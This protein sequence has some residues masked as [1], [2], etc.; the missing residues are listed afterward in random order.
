MVMKMF[1]QLKKM[2]MNTT[3]IKENWEEQKR[4]L[5][6]KFAALTDGDLLFVKG[7]REEMLVKLQKKLG[8]SQEELNKIIAAL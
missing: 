6:Q 4:K 3:E 1:S 5:K 8:K 7:K 2:K